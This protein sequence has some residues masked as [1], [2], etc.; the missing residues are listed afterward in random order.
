MVDQVANIN[1]KSMEIKANL[2]STMVDYTKPKTHR[3]QY[4]K[5]THRVLKRVV[6]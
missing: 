4:R 5:P 2:V 6:N 3:F 1:T